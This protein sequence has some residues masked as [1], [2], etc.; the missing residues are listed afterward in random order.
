MAF[1]SPM[2][3]KRVNVIVRHKDG[4]I[5]IDASMQKAYEVEKAWRFYFSNARNPRN[6]R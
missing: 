2:K 4:S 1:C 3:S 6:T 5:N